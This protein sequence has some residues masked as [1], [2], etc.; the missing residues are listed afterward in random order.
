MKTKRLLLYFLLLWTA[1]AHAQTRQ[2]TL[3]TYA[4]EG[5]KA[6]IRHNPQK[7]EQQW[8]TALQYGRNDTVA[9]NLAQAL[10]LQG[11]HAEALEQY[12]RTA[13][14]TRSDSIRYRARNN[15]GDY[16]FQAKKYQKALE[17][18]RNAL[19]AN[20]KDEIL[21]KKYA[22]TKKLLEKQ[23]KNQKNKQNKK[24]KN[25]KNNKDNKN[26]DNKNDKNN[27]DKQKD[28]NG[29]NDKQNKDKNKNDK[30][31]GNKDN[32]DKNKQNNKD[33]QDQKGDKN[34]QDQKNKGNKDQDKQNQNQQ[35]QNQQGN[36]DKQNK[37]Q[38]GDQGRQK[39]Q[40]G[41][42]GQGKQLKRPSK[43][44][45]EETRYLLN[46]LKNKENQTLRKIRWQKGKGARRKQEKDW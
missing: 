13:R 20:P 8:R 15:A 28:K 29:Q 22:Y 45:P 33:K 7:A 24:N 1:A 23:K 17:A 36:K 12:E 27:K 21:R 43:L 14:Q 16:Y 2:D 41:R 25:N 30:G 10:A 32:K 4:R 37:Q 19:R 44:S 42:E 40:S 35:N 34:K 26:Q 38:P 3:R 6:Y 46:A 31:K 9:Y 5:W 39:N 11:R 18:Y